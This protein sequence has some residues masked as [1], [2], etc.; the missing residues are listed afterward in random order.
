MASLPDVAPSPRPPALTR[1]GV[2]ALLTL[3]AAISPVMPVRAQSLDDR[4]TVAGRVVDADTGAPVADALVEIADSWKFAYTDSS[5]AFVIDAVE[6]GMR[7]FRVRRPG[8][9]DRT[10]MH[11][12]RAGAAPR[13][14]LAA[15][16]LVL[17]GLAIQT[18]RLDR[19]LRDAPYEVRVFGRAALIRSGARSAFDFLHRVAGVQFVPCAPNDATLCILLRGARVAP[20]LVVDDAARRG[21]AEEL[22]RHD[23]RDVY[24]IEVLREGA[25]VRIYTTEFAEDL[26][27]GRR[28]LGPTL[29][30]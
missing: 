10:E 17:E 5:G 25:T 1:P 21:G 26:A 18:A 8:Y 20:A 19:R 9:A 30:K 7:E 16:P 15:R 2:S 4:V 28:W 6:P 22:D 11:E 27:V 14:E 24:R 23:L 13:L 29:R 12:V 3:F